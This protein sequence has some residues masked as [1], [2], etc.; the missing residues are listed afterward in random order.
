[1]VWIDGDDGYCYFLGHFQY[2]TV[3]V[4]PGQRL[5]H[6]EVLGLQGNS[7]YSFAQHVHV[8]RLRNCYTGPDEHNFRMAWGDIQPLS[9]LDI[10]SPSGRSQPISG[11]YRR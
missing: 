1:M 6:G 10:G 4:T 8:N 7:G 3:Q 11:N 9:F 2:N 5:V